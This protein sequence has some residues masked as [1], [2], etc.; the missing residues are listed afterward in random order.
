[1]VPL[2]FIS[3]SSVSFYIEN[4]HSI[5]AFLL[6]N[7]VFFCPKVLPKNKRRRRRR[8]RRKG[9]SL[10]ICCRVPSLLTGIQRESLFSFLSR[11]KQSRAYGYFS[12]DCGGKFDLSYAHLYLYLC[13]YIYIYIYIYSLCC[14]SLRALSFSFLLWGNRS[15]ERNCP[16]RLFLVKKRNCL[17]RSREKKKKRSKSYQTL[18]RIARLF[19][20]LFFFFFFFAFVFQDRRER[21]ESGERQRK[22]SITRVFSFSFLF[23]CRFVIFCVIII[24]FKLTSRACLT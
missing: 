24:V 4:D 9:F 12:A 11:S 23:P 8:R 6:L 15:A 7:A 13:I 18:T 17:L 1:M 2:S 3:F 10:R 22:E 19:S 14:G 5:S 21:D 20:S 16:V